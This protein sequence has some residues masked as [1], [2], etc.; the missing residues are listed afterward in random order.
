MRDIS[1]IETYA[2]VDEWCRDLLTA[3]DA[4]RPPGAHF[5]ALYG[6]ER[7]LLAALV[8]FLLDY[9]PSRDLSLDSILT[10]LSMAESREGDPY[11]KSPLDLLFDQIEDGKR[12]CK[13]DGSD[14]VWAPSNLK[15][16]DGVRPVD[17]GGLSPDEDAALLRWHPLKS[18][19]RADFSLIVSDL[20]C[21]VIDFM[22]GQSCVRPVPEDAPEDASA[23]VGTD[24]GKRGLLTRFLGGRLGRR[25]ECDAR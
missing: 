16:R 1:E 11:F 12:L 4:L 24:K 3:T 6:S 19:P 25:E 21:R 7:N 17:C 18:I 22:D 8:C 15:R 20:T 14:W 10:L 2:D 9:F 5:H 23:R 13:G